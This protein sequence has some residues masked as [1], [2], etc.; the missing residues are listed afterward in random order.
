MRGPNADELFREPTAAN[1]EAKDKLKERRKKL[2]MYQSESHAMKT[3]FTNSAGLR[4]D[5]SPKNERAL[6]P[7]WMNF[8]RKCIKPISSVEEM[9]EKL[10]YYD[11][12]DDVMVVR[13]HQNNCTACNAVDKT[14][15]V[16]CHQSAL[17]LP[18]LHFYEI[19][20]DEV[21][22]LTKGLVRFPQIKG[23]S[24]GQWND[25][26]FKPPTHFREELY[27][28]VEREVKRRKHQGTPVTALQAEEMYF[29]GAGP[30][31]LQTTEEN[32]VLFYRKAQARLHNY[33][34]Q[35]S[36][37][38]TWFYRKFVEPQV[39]DHLKDEWQSK[40]IFGERI[41][42]GPQPPRDFDA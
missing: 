13:Y 1:V 33:W 27:G 28:E 35:V 29:S 12:S 32:I 23:F 34:K 11:K 38:R 30:A 15:E 3:L 22:E 7:L 26:D 37:R 14:L 2:E 36:V 9:R 16:I 20:R 41:F 42:I 25:I 8:P 18:G 39:D 19:N 4:A 31:M 5:M 17:R 21:P 24:G 6:N 10:A 40:S